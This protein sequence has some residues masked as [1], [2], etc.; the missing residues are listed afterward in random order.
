MTQYYCSMVN[1]YIKKQYNTAI[2]FLLPCVAKKPTMA[3]FWCLLGDIYYA[4]K[5]YERAKT[6]YENAIILGSRRL[7]N[8]D[9]PL[10]ISKYKESPQKMIEGCISIFKNQTIY[11]A[12]SK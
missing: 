8:D 7:K 2:K 11:A 3:E 9:W 6:F 5:D 12:S 4:L 10:E 1:C